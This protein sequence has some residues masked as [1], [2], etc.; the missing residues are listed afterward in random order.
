MVGLEAYL[1]TCDTD[2]IVENLETVIAT[3]GTKL[4]HLDA[5]IRK[6]E[7]K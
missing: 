4:K 3:L 1:A 5:A 6:A 2:V 7:G